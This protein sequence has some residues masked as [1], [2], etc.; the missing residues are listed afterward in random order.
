MD[1]SQVNVAV[2]QCSV[3]SSPPEKQQLSRLTFPAAIQ[4]NLLCEPGRKNCLSKLTTGHTV[5][6]TE[7]RTLCRSR[8]VPSGDSPMHTYFTV[9]LSC[10]FNSFTLAQQNQNQSWN[11]FVLFKRPKAE[12]LTI[13][14]HRNS[15]YTK[16]PG[17][18]LKTFPLLN[19]SS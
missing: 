15:V 12:V 9:A 1:P 11:T 10:G 13:H 7:S 18:L 17:I 14:A 8:S 16:I 3:C 4:T 6:L 5:L 19:I 2:C